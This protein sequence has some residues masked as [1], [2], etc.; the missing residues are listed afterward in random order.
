VKEAKQQRLLSER[1]AKQQLIAFRDFY[2]L[3][4]FTFKDIDK[5]LWSE[6][7]TPSPVGA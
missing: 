1:T 3:G 4:S 5:F 2:G 6:R 7:G